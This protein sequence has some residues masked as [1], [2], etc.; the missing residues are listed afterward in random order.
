MFEPVKIFTDGSFDD[1]IRKHSAVGQ[2]GL[3][4]NTQCNWA[5]IFVRDG[6]LIDSLYG[7]S[8]ISPSRN[9]EGEVDAVLNA[10][11]HAS[12]RGFTNVEVYHDYNGIGHWAC[13]EWDADKE[14]SQ[15]YVRELENLR[16]K[17]ASLEFI[18]VRGHQG[19][20]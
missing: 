6:K 3:T 13:G 1:R 15:R 19:N 11:R 17:F 12:E 18:N 7:S 20:Y 2:S 10:L 5:A 4:S 8:A 9:I 16:G 14:V